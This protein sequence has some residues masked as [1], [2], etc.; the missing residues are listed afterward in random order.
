MTDLYTISAEYGQ[1]EDH[2]EIPMFLTTDEAEATAMLQK[3]ADEIAGA[4]GEVRE[5]MAYNGDKSF[6][7]LLVSEAVADV[8]RRGSWDDGIALRL[9]KQPMNVVMSENR[10]L[11][12]KRDVVFIPGSY[13][14]EF[15][16]EE[17]A[18]N[19]LPYVSVYDILAESFE[20][21]FEGWKH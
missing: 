18:K 2:T 12:D 11:V 9:H 14:D 20:Q 5:R 17:R 8:A 13:D 19:D 3:L 6:D 1:W 21:Q 4:Y 16:F 7:N 15:D 10:E